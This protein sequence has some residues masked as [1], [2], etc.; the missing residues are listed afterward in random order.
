LL[1]PLD[2]A[3]KEAV[4]RYLETMVGKKLVLKTGVN[5]EL[6]GGIVAR[7]GGK[8]LDGSTRNRLTFLKKELAEAGR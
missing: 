3:G 2:E 4:T 8:L 1:L 6:I 5:P 7:I